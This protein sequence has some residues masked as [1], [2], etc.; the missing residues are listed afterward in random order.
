MTGG[1]GDV[2]NAAADV[3]AP[4]DDA[5]LMFFR[6]MMFTSPLTRNIPTTAQAQ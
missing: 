6:M 5:P 2:A 1:D 4:G 3:D